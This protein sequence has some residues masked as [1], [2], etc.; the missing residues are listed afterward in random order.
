M[1]W[2]VR[3]LSTSALVDSDRNHHG[4][5]TTTRTTAVAA[6]AAAAGSAG[7]GRCRE[8]LYWSTVPKRASESS[9]LFSVITGSMDPVAGRRQ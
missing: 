8:N 5:K 1:H 7:L 9:T 6:A 3:T 4:K 2:L